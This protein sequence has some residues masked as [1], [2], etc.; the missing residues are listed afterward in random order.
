MDVVDRYFA[1]W[2]E[3]APA[4]VEATF[5]D[6]G[7]YTDPATGGPLSGP[8]IAAY[9]GGLCA[10]FP[11]V[12]FDIV[13]RISA[14]TGVV[15][16][17]W[18]MRGTN[19][20]P[21]PGGMPPTGRSIELPGADFIVLDGDRIRSVQ[22]YFD[23]R[24]FAE[25][26]GVQV[27]TLPPPMGPVAFGTAVSVQTGKRTQ[28][29][30]VSMTVIHLRDEAEAAKMRQ[31]GQGVL[32]Q[33]MGRGTTMLLRRFES[34]P[35]GSPEGSTSTRDARMSGI[36]LMLGRTPHPRARMRAQR[37]WPPRRPALASGRPRTRR[38]RRGRRAR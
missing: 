18:I 20:G 6:G 28:P 10:S 37:R 33:A 35:R 21:A 26:L 30:A 8:A 17:Q 38:T 15:A 2:N 27:V 12:S 25:Q 7:T 29:G 22:G 9:V 31:Y 13:T 11:D 19:F 4:S 32:T 36:W 5:A 23:Q 3:H 14:G 16:A 34:L 24:A 1:A